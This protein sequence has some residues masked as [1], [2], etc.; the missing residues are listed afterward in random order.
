MFVGK[1]VEEREFDGV[2][3]LHKTLRYQPFEEH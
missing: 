1:L 3:R 2:E